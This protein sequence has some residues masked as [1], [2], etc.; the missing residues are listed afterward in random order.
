MRRLIL[1]VLACAWPGLAAAQSA[2]E[3]QAAVEKL[4]PGESVQL[5]DV[6]FTMHRK[7]A[8]TRGPDGWYAARST[9]GGFTVRL[10]IPYNDFSTATPA[11]DGA[12][13]ASDAVGGSSAESAR[14]LANCTRRSDRKVP[15]GWPATVA[16]GIDVKEGTAQRRPIQREGFEGVELRVRSATRGVFLARFLAGHGRMC[17]ISVE[18]PLAADG[19][20]AD[21]AQAFLDSF[22]LAE[23]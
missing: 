11:V 21:T 15:A 1:A 13:I 20:L 16:D 19:D 7:L 17:Q 6:R 4:Q 10:P 23:E 12:M 8:G 14:F 5:G 22:T 3:D 9:G 2:G 18:Y